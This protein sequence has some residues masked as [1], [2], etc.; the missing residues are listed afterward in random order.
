ML[1]TKSQD[2]I[3]TKDFIQ[4]TV[5]QTHRNHQDVQIVMH[6]L[7]YEEGL[8][9]NLL[10]YSRCLLAEQ[11]Q[12]KAICLSHHAESQ[13]LTRLGIP[14][15]YMNR[16]PHH[17]K[18]TNINYWLSEFQNKKVFL[19]WYKEHNGLEIVRA[20]FSSRFSPDLD[21]HILYPFVLKTLESTQELNNLFI[22]E[23]IQENDFS[24][25]KII[26]RNTEVN[27][28][29]LG[30]FH[31]GILISNSE[32]GKSSVHI[33]P[34]VENIYQLN[35]YNFIDRGE[36][37]VSI[38]HVGDLKQETVATAIFNVYKIA[39]TGI[40]YLLHLRTQEVI[41]PVEETI[42]LVKKNTMLTNRLVEAVKEVLGESSTNKLTLY[43][44]LIDS[45]KTL[46]LFVKHIM[47]K[48]IGNHMKLFQNI[49]NRIDSVINQL[50][51][52]DE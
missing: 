19:R 16:C 40:S 27:V 20:I 48:E 22:E 10:D 2:Y 5:E 42:E 1:F 30:T 12:E 11:H 51:S 24:I 28:N 21:D 32:V 35:E 4:N 23:F 45:I 8:P 7:R 44:V 47:E 41:N 14:I 29:E 13:L 52:E 37:Y 46:P 49:D 15:S 9:S 34:I 17:L 39:Q 36:G 3:S 25:L 18:T 31:A 43:K 33:Q 50:L 26:F 38:K 6:D